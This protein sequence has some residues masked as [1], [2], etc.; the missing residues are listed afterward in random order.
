M[1][2]ALW[3]E[4]TTRK[5][6]FQWVEG[7]DAAEIAA[8]LG[9]TPEDV[10]RRVAQAAQTLGS[11][12]KK[13]AAPP[14]P[15]P[16][17]AARPIPA[18]RPVEAAA[19]ARIL[20][21]AVPTAEA[22]REAARDLSRKAPAAQAEV[23]APVRSAPAA[24][25][26]Q[27]VAAAPAPVREVLAP[28]VPQPAPSPAPAPA[29][30]SAPALPATAGRSPLAAADGGEGVPFMKAGLFDC[31]FP[32]WSDH[33]GGSIET[34]RVC[35]CRVVTGKRWCPQHY[36]IVFEPMRKPQRAA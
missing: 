12:P 5:A 7:R 1:N 31:V 26:R 15:A 6:V 2:D 25:P 27:A 28:A 33:E 10:I 9:T 17:V 19:K 11:K 35:G 29:P 21:R 4:E 20:P 34:K 14:R 8:D 23:P 13:P 16:A 32:L 3:T 22:P 24:P 36:A 18:A 30:A